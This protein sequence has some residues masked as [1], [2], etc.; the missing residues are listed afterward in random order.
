MAED[1]VSGFAGARDEGDPACPRVH[2]WKA[3]MNGSGGRGTVCVGGQQAPACERAGEVTE[4]QRAP[5][6]GQGW[7]LCR[8]QFGGEGKAKTRG[9]DREG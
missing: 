1:S 6:L 9:G 2:T 5:A 4:W 8:S 7:L 3:L